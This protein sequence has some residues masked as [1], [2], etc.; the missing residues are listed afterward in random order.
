[1]ERKVGLVLKG[2]TELNP[3]ER[4]EFITEIIK[5]FQ[6]GVTEQVIRKSIMDSV[7]GSTRMTLGPSPTSCPCCGK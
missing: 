5:L 3:Q 4:Q 1:M 7:Q 2:F 6:G